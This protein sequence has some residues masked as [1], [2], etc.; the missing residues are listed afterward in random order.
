MEDFYILI[1][2]SKT[3]I[4]KKEMKIQNKKKKKSGTSKEPWPD[5][6]EHVHVMPRRKAADASA[7]KPE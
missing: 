7:I 1:S 6:R 3:G 5:T 4:E 2:G